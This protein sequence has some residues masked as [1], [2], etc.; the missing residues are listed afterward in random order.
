VAT[1]KQSIANRST[2]SPTIE[3]LSHHTHTPTPPVDEIEDIK[4]RNRDSS[5][6][7]EPSAKDKHSSQSA[8]EAPLKPSINDKFVENDTSSRNLDAQY[9]PS[10]SLEIGLKLV[11]ALPPESQ[12]QYSKL[13]NKPQLMI[14]SMVMNQ[15]FDCL[16]ALYD[17]MPTVFREELFFT[18]ARKA[19]SLPS[20]NYDAQMKVGLETIRG[21]VQVYE[22]T[23]LILTGDVAYDEELRKKHRFPD[24]PNTDLALRLLAFCDEIKAAYFTV[25]LCE[26]YEGYVTGFVSLDLNLRVVAALKNMLQYGKVLFLKHPVEAHSGIVEL[27]DSFLS[28]LDLM[29]QIVQSKKPLQVN[30]GD[31]A[32]QNKARSLRD[33][34]LE[35]NEFEIARDL[36]LRT[37]T[38]VEVVTVAWGM[39]YI[40][41]GRYAEARQMLVPL[42]TPANRSRSA[43]SS[44]HPS[45]KTSAVLPAQTRGIDTQMVVEN[46]VQTLDSPKTTSVAAT[47]S[48]SSAGQLAR[49]GSGAISRASGGLGSSSSSV[50]K[51]SNPPVSELDK[52]RTM[53]GML[54][55]SSKN[56]ISSPQAAP[57]ASSS[58][59]NQRFS[60]D[61]ATPL[62][63]S[64]KTLTPEVLECL[65]YLEKFGTNTTLLKFYMKHTLLELAC[66]HVLNHGIDAEVFLERIV[67]PCTDNSLLGEL[68]SALEKSDPHL[69]KSQPYLMIICKYLNEQKAYKTLVTFQVFMRD[70]TRAALT[71]I[72]IF[73]DTSDQNYRPKCLEI[74]KDYFGEALKEISSKPQNSNASAVMSATDISSYVMKIEIQMEVLKALTPL[75]PKLDT[76]LKIP[77]LADYTLFGPPPQRTTLTWILMVHKLDLGLRVLSDTIKRDEWPAVFTNAGIYAARH[78]STSYA[79]DL[80]DNVKAAGAD[81]EWIDLLLKAE[82]EVFAKEKKDPKTSERMAKMIAQP[83]LRCVA[84]IDA[85]KLKSAYL[86]A[87]KLDDP[88]A[89]IALILPR[90]Q[91][92]NDQSVVKLCSNFVS[93]HTAKVSGSGI[94]I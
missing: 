65:F 94:N 46:I 52:R 49:V 8:S 86:E 12:P 57:S 48:P 74:A 14:E 54:Q 76:T 35:L 45:R 22:Q 32:D 26:S 4:R 9:T 3:R 78:F 53:S 28:Q 87:V 29:L 15:R 70:Y 30:I 79:S 44:G 88:L 64:E 68:K 34:L 50:T 17:F 61:S 23:T 82:T 2:V 33:K 92:D 37:N 84:L 31:F 40:K 21:P 11:S 6:M 93:Q 91:A 59:S 56:A 67:I 62:A 1:L 73:M 41:S 16:Q 24:P 10:T 19:L 20:T 51:G 58:S 25:Q 36:C 42:L 55:S 7:V 85:G 5:N 83:R 38:P 13:V 39:Q 72:R 81:T 77:N 63:S 27:V 66:N 75:L 80:I 89:L 60:I 43:S 71:C 69:M 90:A 18:Y 47:A